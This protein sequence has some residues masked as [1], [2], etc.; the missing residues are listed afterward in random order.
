[1]P[2]GPPKLYLSSYLEQH[3]DEYRHRLLRVSQNGEWNEWF[4][5]FLDAVVA[6]AGDTWRKLT[7][8]EALQESYHKKVSGASGK[9]RDAVDHLFFVSPVVRVKNISA[10]TGLTRQRASDYIETLVQSGI[11]SP[12][13]KQWGR[14]YFANEIMSVFFGKASGAPEPGESDSGGT[15]KETAANEST[16]PPSVS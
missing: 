7:E 4:G 3:D 5:F 2:P 14:L 12:G 8:L 15:A 11:L 1:L 9:L 6:E 13:R 16:K 10:A